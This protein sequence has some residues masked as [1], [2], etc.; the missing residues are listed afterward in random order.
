MRAGRERCRSTA[1]RPEASPSNPTTWSRRFGSRPATTGDVPLPAA[2]SLGGRPP[3]RRRRGRAA[4]TSRRL[5]RRAPPAPGRSE[6]RVGRRR[7]EPMIRSRTISR[8]RRGAGRG[9]RGPPGKGGRR[10]RGA[11]AGA[12]T[13][14]RAE[15]GI[16]ASRWM[17]WAKV[18]RN[19]PSSAPHMPSTAN[20][21]SRSSRSTRWGVNFALISVSRSSP[22]SKCTTMS[23]PVN[24]TSVASSARSRI[25]IHCS[26]SFHR[27]TWRKRSGS[28]SPP[29]CSLRTWSTLRLKSA[30]TPAASS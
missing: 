27:A 18:R 13:R 17:G 23:A 16:S 20:P 29:S 30:V 14:D 7:S 28:K 12:R 10:V 21:A 24:V 3:Q 2:T 4:R 11:G 1:V 8:A 26:S 15:R 9:G 22:S 5:D 19:S 25:S 6:R